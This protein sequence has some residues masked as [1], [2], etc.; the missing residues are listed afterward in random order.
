MAHLQY[1]KTPNIS[2]FFQTYC[3]ALASG[4][5]TFQTRSRSRY[6]A[7]FFIALFANIRTRA[8]S[9]LPDFATEPSPAWGNV[10]ITLIGLVLSGALIAIDIVEWSQV[11]TVSNRP[12]RQL[13]RRSPSR[14]SATI[15]WDVWWKKGTRMPNAARKHRKV[16]AFQTKRW[17]HLSCA[18]RANGRTASLS[19]FHSA[20]LL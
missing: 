18:D 14:F 8:P 3:K 15:Y 20:L 16:A 9:C 1:S 17:A 12:F 10:L 11:P 6:V 4:V 5:K 19:R 13:G 2:F 7:R